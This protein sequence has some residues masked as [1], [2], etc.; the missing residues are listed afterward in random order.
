MASIIPLPNTR[1]SGMLVRQ[2]LLAQMQGDQLDLF[3]LQNQVSTGQRFTLPSEDAPAARRAMTLQRLLERKTQLRSNIDTGQSFLKSTDVALNNV[4]GL[5]G[6]IRGV[7]LGVSGTT[8]TDSERQAAITEINRAIEQLVAVGNTQFRGRYLFA[9]S[10][11][12]V[13]PY[14]YNGSYVTYHGDSSSLQSYSDLG[15]LFSTNATGQDVFGGISN[16]VLGGEDLNPEV[17]ADTP[18]SS[19]RGGRG[20]SPNGALQISDGTST[21]IVDI[22]R[23]A[24]V[25]DVVRLIEANPPAG[26]R[27]SASINGQGLTL[28]LDSALGGNL[29]VKEVASGK[30]ARE[31]GILNTVGALTNPL[32][33]SDLNPRV[34]KTTPLD[35]LLGSKARTRLV[36]AG[37]NNDLLIQAAVN[38]AQYNGATIQLVDDEL[39]RASPGV[40]QGA[41]YAQYSATARE[42]EASLRFSGSGNDLTLTA[43]AAGTA[44]NN[45]SIVVVGAP[46]LGNAAN[47][48]YN[49]SSK[50]LTV[51]VDDAGATTVDAVLNAINAEGTF[52]AASDESAEGIG[53]YNP[54]ATIQPSDISNLQGN[55]GN[56]GGAANT[57]YVHVRANVS[58]ANNVAAAIN[59]EG[60]FT[61]T[62]DSL[63][64]SHG[65]QA[66]TQTVSLSATAQTSGGSGFPFDKD[67]GIRVVSGQTT[68]TLS[69]DQAD[70]V[71]DVLNILNGSEAGLYAEINAEGT[72]INVRSRLSGANLQIGE[73]GG[74]T[75]T[76]LGIRSYSGATR[77]EDLNHGVGVPTRRDAYQGDLPDILGDFTIRASDGVGTVDLNVDT[78]G[79]TTIQD[80]IA[81]I[82]AHPLNNA[83]GVQITAQLNATGNGIDLVDGGGQPYEIISGGQTQPANFLESL[84]NIVNDFNIT[85]G[86]GPGA[87]HLDF[88]VSGAE[89]VQDVIDLIN[90]RPENS[91]SPVVAARLNAT[92]NGIEIVN[93]SGAA[94]TVTA[95]EG[96]EAAEYLGLVAPGETTATN[97]LG[98]LSGADN[99]F[100]ETPSVF[101]TL[102][103]LKDALAANDITAIEQAISNID[104]D[105]DRVVFSRSEV[106]A[107]QQALDVTQQNLEDEDVQLRSALSEELEV[108]LVEAISN[109]TARQISLEASLKAT[110]SILQMSLLSYL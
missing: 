38:G 25:G 6:D 36:S 7:A 95:A 80:V 11:T 13:E 93:L 100:H 18:L 16:E 69:F 98:T 51:T 55:T 43:N 12:N 97:A 45:V 9:G 42:A 106:G 53:S 90:N 40:A 22:S 54:A 103:R 5:L 67:S 109:L 81:L 27:V 91:P 28:Q 78:A 37:D 79:A 26:R 15:V 23:A 105:L 84:P 64:T 1:V 35:D 73:N 39:L 48:S 4:A 101:T 2:R 19:L 41:E 8:S 92:G 72:G 33:G 60:T 63:D 96:S 44:F 57:L 30:A 24:T 17:T 3:R 10:Q 86:L 83:A 88:D 46:A 77:L 59:A 99:N 85:L 21:V 58:N 82:N 89:T 71:E 104:V 65:S 107:R 50:Q 20:I 76:Q 49:S 56:S 70:S 29:T 108:D 32:V 61:A 102:I 47:V 87:V 34:T 110:A 68:Y 52:T 31:L 94:V 75:A 66:G 74:Q 14:S 62:L